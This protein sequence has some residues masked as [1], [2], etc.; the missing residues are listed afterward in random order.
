[1]SI[2]KTNKQVLRILDENKALR[3][4]VA[5]LRQQLAAVKETIR[6]TERGAGRL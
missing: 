2:E 6:Q 1:M 3:R 5:Y 4:E